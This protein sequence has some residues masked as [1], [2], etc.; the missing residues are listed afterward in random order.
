MA[1]DHGCGIMGRGD[2]GEPDREGDDEH[3]KRQD[4]VGDEIAERAVLDH[5][6]CTL[7]ST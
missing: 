1:A 6:Y 5:Q 7:R 4:G 3:A 2:E